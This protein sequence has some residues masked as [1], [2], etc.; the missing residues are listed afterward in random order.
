MLNSLEIGVSCR[1][2]SGRRVFSSLLAKL[3]SWRDRFTPAPP[4]DLAEDAPHI[5][6]CFYRADK[7][8]SRA[9][10]HAGLGLAICKTIVEAERGAIEAFSAPQE[11]TTSIVR[12]PND[13]QPPENSLP[14]SQNL[15]PSAQTPA[16][17][18]ARNRR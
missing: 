12:I 14:G 2:A 13:K 5:F 10:G 11:G 1:F 4:C 9:R 18:L 8:R 3:A 17:G 6:D 15:E 7:A 16:V